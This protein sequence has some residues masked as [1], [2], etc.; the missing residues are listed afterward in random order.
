MKIAKSLRQTPIHTMITLGDSITWG[1]DVDDKSECWPNRL[2]ELISRFQG[3]EVR[4]INQAIGSNVLTPRC[5]AYE[6][7]AKYS[8]LERVEGDVL[9]HDP[10]LLLVA[11][12]TNDSRGGTDTETFRCE[13]QKLID[14]VRTKSPNTLIV[15]LNMFYMRREAFGSAD[16]VWGHSNYNV[17][18]V[19]NRVIE[20]LA[21]DNGLILAD[22]F[23]AMEGVDWLIDADTV[24][25]N[26]LG[27]Q[28]IANR[29]FEAIVRNA[30]FTAAAMPRETNILGFVNKYGNG[31]DIE[32]AHHPSN[33]ESVEVV[34]KLFK[35]D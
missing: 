26:P 23:G 25:P 27:H 28:I 17:M 22:V 19:Y 33:E 14:T 13:Y 30:A 11:Y 8:G 1:Y 29:V 21:A 5:P 16:P 31:P 15:L 3:E 12:G 35:K 32:S 2:A 6:A 4:L 10:D 9:A 20:Q 24:H 18:E 34:R 7:S